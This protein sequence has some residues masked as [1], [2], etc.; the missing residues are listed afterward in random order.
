MATDPAFQGRIAFAEDYDMD[1]AHYLV[2]GADI[3]LNTPRR[4]QEACGTSGMKA[5]LNG[6]LNLS[7]RDGWWYE[8]YNGLNGWAIGERSVE[9]AGEQDKDDAEYIYHLLEHEI[10]PLF[11]DRDTSDVPRGWI[12]V[13]KEAIR[14]VM[15]AFCAR[16]MVKE[17][18]EQMYRPAFRSVQS[19]KA[20]PVTSKTS[21]L[22]SEHK[23][24]RE[25][26]KFLTNSLSSLAT[27]SSQ[28]TSQSTQLKDQITLYRWSLYD[29]REAIRRHIDLDERIFEM[30]LS[31]TSVKDIMG[32]H[33][34]IQKQV[35]NAISLAENAVYNKSH[36][37]ELN[38]C[39]SDIKEAVNRICESIETHTAK[40]DRLLKQVPKGS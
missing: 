4:L 33:E 19:K 22:T 34:T 35:D 14:S 17:Y 30:L 2:Q 21:D 16:R 39:A 40:E 10:V 29:F 7:I 36:R 11:Y 27:K 23:A 13:V 9:L 8:G 6:V 3:W 32:E 28:R 25:H 31:S 15:P 5:S 18:I 12:R 38:K 20:M 26:M 37:E 1:L 24:I